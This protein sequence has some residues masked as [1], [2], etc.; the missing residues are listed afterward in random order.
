MRD[1]QAIT[2]R[3]AAGDD[4]HAICVLGQVVNAMHHAAW[5]DL[6]AGAADP[7]RDASHW[8][9]SIDGE[10]SAAFVAVAGDDLAGFVTVAWVDETSSLLLPVRLA[11]VNTLCVD[12]TRQR[13]G[14]GRALMARAEQWATQA[15]ALEV[16]LSVWSFNRHARDLYAA[17]GY[18]ERSSTLGKRLERGE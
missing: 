4:L 3:R 9:A 2:Y 17:L 12:P 1:T 7:A 5:P 10:R 14:I 11:R 15:G 16:R 18:D 13:R 6:F 8:R